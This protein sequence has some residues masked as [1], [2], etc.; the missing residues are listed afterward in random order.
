MILFNKIIFLTIFCKFILV[1]S[2][3]SVD[4]C[5][6]G[7]FKFSDFWLLCEFEVAPFDIN[8]APLI[9]SEPIF[10]ERLSELLSRKL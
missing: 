7:I 4:A 2:S 8:A 10:I 9:I 5:L 3:D 6:K 1:F